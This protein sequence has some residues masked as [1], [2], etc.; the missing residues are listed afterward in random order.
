MK[1]NIKNIFIVLFIVLSYLAKAQQVYPVRVNVNAIPPYSTYLSDYFG[2]GATKLQATL[3]LTDNSEPVIDVKL[4]VSIE[5]NGIKIQT[6]SLLNLS[7]HSL[8]SGV[9]SVLQGGD[10]ADYFTTNNLDYQGTT[11]TQL[12]KNNNKL[13][14]GGYNICVE[15]YE[16]TTGKLISNKSCTY[17]YVQLNDEPTLSL[18]A[19]GTVIGQTNP[20][21]VN[22]SWQPSNA[23]A[24]AVPLEYQLQVYEV[25][26]GVTQP[27]YA[28]KNNQAQ[29]VFES[30]WQQATTYQY[31]AT[32]AAL[33]YGKIY[34]YRVQA[35]FQDQSQELKNNGYSQPCYF[36]FGYP[37]GGN[38]SLLQPSA[39]AS[40][41]ETDPL[42]F[43]WS[44]PD[45]VLINQKIDYVLNIYKLDEGVTDP[46]KATTQGELF[47]TTTYSEVLPTGAYTTL[48]TQKLD[49]KSNYAWEVKAL[50][51]ET[52]IATSAL[53]G[54]A[55]P[56][57][58]TGFYA[59]DYWVEV[60]STSNSD[61]TKLSGKGTIEIDATGKKQDFDFKDLKISYV[62]GNMVLSS[63]TVQA[64]LS[65]TSLIALEP[66]L[67]ENDKAYFHPKQFEL[68]SNG[69]S[70]YGQIWWQLPHAVQNVGI[71][72]IK[73][74]ANWATYTD[75]KIGGTFKLA[76]NND[77][78]LME[79]YDFTLK[80]DPIS[81]FSVSNNIY[82][83]TL[84]GDVVMPAVVKNQ[85]S[86]DRN[87]YLPF[88][89]A[90]QLYYFTNKS[91]TP[92]HKIQPV[93]NVGLY[94]EP[95]LY[96]F[97]L[98][99]SKSPIRKTTDV[100]WKGVVF[101]KSNI[102]FQKEFDKNNQLN[103]NADTRYVLQL[104][105]KDTIDNYI[106]SDGLTFTF[107][108][109]FS[110]GYKV[111][112]NTFPAELLTF[113]VDIQKSSLHTS[114][115]A[116]NMFI[117]FISTTHK[118]NF[119]CPV[120]VSGINSG[121]MLD[122][123][124]YSFVFNPSKNREKLDLKI[125]TAVF[126]DKERLEINFSLKWPFLGLDLGTITQLSL[127][128]NYKA[129]FFTPNGTRLL[130]N[131]VSGTYSS[132]PYVATKIGA[133]RN[134]GAYS[135][136]VGG[137]IT[138]SEDIAG[139]SGAPEANFYSIVPNSMI[140]V[141]AGLASSD[142]DDQ[143]TSTSTTSTNASSSASI[144][145]LSV[146]QQ[147]EAVAESYNKKVG[148]K[149]DSI[150]SINTTVSSL[151]KLDSVA[152]SELIQIPEA[153]NT[154]LDTNKLEIKGGLR[155][156]LSEKE[157]EVLEQFID[158]IIKLSY[159]LLGKKLEGIATKLNT[160][161]DTVF[162]KGYKIGD[163][164][165]SKQTHKLVDI[166][167]DK[168]KEAFENSKS[169]DPSELIDQ[170][171]DTVADELA[172]EI[173]R[174]VRAAVD[175]NIKNPAKNII[176]VQI[177][178][179]LNIFMV[180]FLQKSAHKLLNDEITGEDILKEFADTL[181]ERLEKSAQEAINFLKPKKLL[182]SLENTI[183]DAIEGIDLGNVA[184]RLTNGFVS[185]SKK[186]LQKKWE[187][188]AEDKINGLVSDAVKDIPGLNAVAGPT[189][190]L[191][192]DN[193]GEKLKKGDV[194]GI[195]SVDATN[196]SVNTKY[197][198][199]SGKLKNDTSEVYGNVWRADVKVTI[200]RPKSFAVDAIFLSGKKKGREYWFCQIAPGDD[201][202]TKPG[203]KLSKELKK[204]NEPVDIGP[205]QLVAGT[206]RV[207]KHMKE[208]NNGD[209]IVPDTTV[210][211]GA[212][213]SLVLYD[214]QAEGKNLRLALEAEFIMNEDDN[215]TISFDGNVQV[216]SSTVSF[217]KIDQ[218]AMVIGTLSIDYSSKNS[219]F[220]ALGT[221]ELKNEA[222]CAS[223][224][225]G[226]E[227]KPGFFSVDIGTEKNPIRVVPACNGW[228][229][230][231]FLHLDTYNADF[232]AGISFSVYANENFDIGVVSGA[233][234]VKA[235]AELMLKAGITHNPKFILNYVELWAH[236]YAEVYVDYSTALKSGHITL[237]SIDVEVAGRIQFNPKPAKLSAKAKGRACF[238]IYCV[239]FDASFEKNV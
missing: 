27:L 174:S 11:S 154:V 76:R 141:E 198:S 67:E 220:I 207:Y 23:V 78:V 181:P 62:A 227:S 20:Q 173:S 213:L 144:N 180:S 108:R 233:V 206:G 12:Q 171:A 177:V 81:E 147:Q 193:L 112:F 232:G 175:K 239:S 202:N 203:G 18:P 53:S 89:D 22:F 129:G 189:I 178:D 214:K 73:S 90:N 111:S 35:R 31:T 7:T 122:L 85:F 109:K 80:F 29:L 116:G 134:G 130:Q 223:G 57:L 182:K 160:K 179:S 69:I 115:L 114:A 204:F 210:D 139:S 17:I 236:V 50:T 143:S 148:A 4:R 167:A 136:G 84:H 113:T 140:P 212:Y 63:G 71:A 217:N 185:S 101:E 33:T 87:V 172:R 159:G 149:V 8:Y 145:T 127:W 137:T 162:N 102:F 123:E 125:E 150:I 235:G 10:L 224:T 75:Y 6:K 158:E 41:K 187:N 186:E 133:G 164:Y 54:F 70:L 46:T 97:D 48:V 157:Y 146:D 211:F 98:S 100:A 126:K 222:L 151:L 238:L 234:G 170:V 19:C 120:T 152:A 110:S 228:G 93:T 231:G 107:L 79:P 166:I 38:I 42:V 184:S 60:Q 64:L 83:I 104:D 128:G 225:I 201:K 1:K 26:T 59:G 194:K 200:K 9:P 92:S 195:I 43:S 176:K 205:V 121:Y 226:F 56:S 44:K 82:S 132:Y 30:D 3:T 52:I 16:A 68:S 192:F 14:E 163:K 96:T 94:I 142:D 2:E 40:F 13:A 99:E 153:G 183:G 196:I 55:G 106:N 216:K 36:Y 199:F 165:I 32:D 131:Q 103:F 237:V 124:N 218:N 209:G 161:I 105:E 119:N 117:P 77:F 86:T 72:Y 39:S 155:A 15:V 219:H 51:D 21:I 197:V 88:A 230:L 168:T 28:I 45:N 190:Q 138:I 66:T 169:Y 37:T 221:M 208:V 191:N 74:S 25:N 95:L 34:T 49:R 135:L 229:G 5:G 58:V 65:D 47:Y 156:K 61:L 24:G 91:K 118:F 215:Y 188:F